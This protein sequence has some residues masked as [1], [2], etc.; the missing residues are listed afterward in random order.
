[1]DLEKTTYLPIA[2]EKLP[3]ALDEVYTIGNPNDFKA[4][5]SVTSGKISALRMQKKQAQNFIQAT[6]P[7]TAGFAGAPL[8][9]AYGNVLGVHDR[10][11]SVGTIFSYFTPIH[12]ALRALNIR[13]TDERDL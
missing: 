8:L 4:R 11:N 1:M 2:D 5:S 6:I 12:D 10:R 9:D 7:T 3:N 13:L